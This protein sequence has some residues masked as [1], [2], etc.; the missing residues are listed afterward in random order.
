MRQPPKQ[1]TAISSWQ[2]RWQSQ[3]NRN[4]HRHP[5]AGKSGGAGVAPKGC[6]ATW[7]PASLDSAGV[8]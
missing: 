2:L 8:G 1:T 3:P 5:A 7:H 4:R 6:R